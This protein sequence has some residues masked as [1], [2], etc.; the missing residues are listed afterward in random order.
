[1]SEGTED[2]L[3]FRPLSEKRRHCPLR[4]ATE[5]QRTHSQLLE[6]SPRTAVRL[7]YPPESVQIAVVLA[8]HCADLCMH[9]TSA[10]RHYD[11]A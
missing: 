2:D 4:L 5:S 6:R 8:Q 11:E 10:L 3:A 7:V 9:M 1:M